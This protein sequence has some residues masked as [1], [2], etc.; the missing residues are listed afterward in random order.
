[1]RRIAHRLTKALVLFNRLD[2]LVPIS[3]NRWALVDRAEA[4]LVARKRVAEH[5]MKAL[6]VRGREQKTGEQPACST[7]HE[8]EVEREAIDG[9]AHLREVREAPF[10]DVVFGLDRDLGRCALKVIHAREARTPITRGRLQKMT[11]K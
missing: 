2:I 8:C 9:A 5:L 6:G 7:L 3:L 1:M 10:G 11:T 4:V